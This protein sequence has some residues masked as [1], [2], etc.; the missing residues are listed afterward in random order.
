MSE[1]KYA[2][3]I[4]TESIRTQP[5]PAGFL[6]RMEDQRKEGN[7]LESTH[8]F[9]LNDSIAKGAFYTDCVWMWDLKGSKGVQ[10]EIAHS[11]DFDEV[12]GFIGTNRENPR[13]LNGEI[14]LWLE[15]ER[16]VITQSC[17]IFVPRGMK[18]LPLIFKRIESPIFFFTEGNG[19]SY[20]RS[21]GHES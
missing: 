21:S 8:M 16:Y 10:V 2:K 14:E 11:H 4:I 20:T 9:S 19:T 6:K 3:Y 18:H 15:D 17:L 13:D 7:Y 12:L 1:K 5:P